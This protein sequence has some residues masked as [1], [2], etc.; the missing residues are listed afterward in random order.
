MSSQGPLPWFRFNGVEVANAARVVEYLRNG[1]GNTPH[2][3]LGDGDLCDVLYRDDACAPITYTSPSA[4]PAPWYDA[5][6]PGAAAFLGVVPL[7][8]RGYDSTIA[9]TITERLQ[10]LQG[11][12]W[13]QQRR[14][15]RKWQFQAAIIAADD[16]GAEYGLR[17]LTAVLAA[18]ACDTC[19]TGHLEVRLVCPTGCADTGRW[20]SYDASLVSGPIETQQWSPGYESMQ[21]ILAGCRTFT[22]VEFEIDAGNPFLYKPA[23]D[24]LASTAVT[25]GGVTCEEMLAYPGGFYLGAV[26]AGGDHFVATV[27]DDAWTAQVTSHSPVLWYR[28]DALAGV[29][30]DD[31]GSA[32]HD[33]TYINFPT[34]GQ[35]GATADSPSVLFQ[36]ALNQYLQGS[37]DA[38]YSITTTGALTV[39][40]WAK[41][42]VAAT[43]PEEMITK[44]TAAGNQREWLAERYATGEVQWRVFAL[45]GGTFLTANTFGTPSLGEFHFYVAT[46]KNTAGTVTVK[47]YLDSVLVDTDS[48]SFG[49][50][51]NGTAPVEIGAREG[52]GFPFNGWID[53]AFICATELSQTDINNLYAATQPPICC[54]VEPPTLNSQ[55]VGAIFTF[56]T[57]LGAG[58]INMLAYE[59]CPRSGLEEPVLQLQLA[60]IPPYSEVVVDCSQRTVTITTTDPATGAQTVSDGQ[61]LLLP[62]GGATI[63]PT[64][65]IEVRSCDDIHCLCVSVA[66]P[67]TFAGD[68][69]VSIETQLRE[70]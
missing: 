13:A 35:P 70:G 11:G 54:E 31:L 67:C 52:A 10:G 49:S 25:V 3:E 8:L 66:D 48:F 59:D 36:K 42:D 57:T 69:F 23:E 26:P 27:A 7:M 32:N 2:W 45:A 20:F 64:Q 55:V 39:A 68:T 21:G 50:I 17:W 9:R 61:Y 4:D 43:G 47:T 51:G 1:L 14:A 56:E 30:E 46:M 5:A 60:E 40:W 65:W 15:P 16:S 33:G 29:T 44:W 53:E 18:T 34:L 19:D 6:E 63:D 41:S 38:A 62:T 28:M 12:V 22:I 58:V 24:C 37:D